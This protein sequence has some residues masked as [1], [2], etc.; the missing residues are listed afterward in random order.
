MPQ[1]S[2]SVGRARRPE[3]LPQTD[4]CIT[5]HIADG[6]GIVGGRLEDVADLV[7]EEVVLAVDAVAVDG[8]QDGDAGRKGAGRERGR[9]AMH[10][11]RPIR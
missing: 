2:A 9:S 1:V 8:E 10:G 5:V 3:Y 4:G 7:V 11:R 6:F